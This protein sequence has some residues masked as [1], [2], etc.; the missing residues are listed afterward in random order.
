MKKSTANPV[1]QKSL[2]SLFLA[3]VF[4]MSCSKSAQPTS[5]AASITSFS[6][7]QGIN[8]ISVNSNATIAA[9]SI[10]LF[11]PPGS[12]TTALIPTFTLSD[13]ASV[14]TVNGASQQSA[15]TAVN[16]SQPLNYTVTNRTGLKTN[17]VVSLTTDM[18]LIDTAVSKYMAKYKVPA[19]SIAITKDEKLVYAKSYGQADKATGAP[20]A[21]NS[22]YRIASLSK[23]ITS[24]TIMKLLD[25]GKIHMEDKVF[26]PGAILGNDFGTKPYGPHIT[27]ITVDELLHHTA[28]GWP[29]DGTD[30]MFTNPTL[31]A[32]QLITWTLDNRPLDTIP[33][34]AYAYS[35]FGYCI[36]G[37]VIE[38]ITGTTYVQAAQNLV[39]QP[40]GIADMQIAGNTL[41]E[42]LPNEVVY[43]GQDG[44]Q[45][46]IYNI[47]RMDSHGGWLASA[48]DLARFLVHVDG[49][50]P[51]TDIISPNA[52]S[53]MTTPSTANNEYAC[54]WALNGNNWWHDGSLPGTQTEQ[55]RIVSQGNLNF[56]ILTN[57]RNNA[58][59]AVSAMD[60]IFWSSVPFI[61]SWPSYDLF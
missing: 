3:A 32:Q 39:L 8:A 50:S 6:L 13:P 1:F 38:K 57:T 46:Y 56:S 19:L 55:A 47:T 20:A 34:A 29:N 10:F 54:G 16:L 9:D 40:C 17:Y 27:D 5:A 51:S 7:Q 42:K 14:V 35:N 61:S 44:E 37:R 58:N 31:T 15:I 53:V 26:G 30:P 43:Y 4:A 23:Q 2:F 36:L 21:N 49:L 11:L 24:V 28:G 18:S 41:A 25:Q 60:D 52:V 48:T 22:L 33:G 59:N 12:A 45:P